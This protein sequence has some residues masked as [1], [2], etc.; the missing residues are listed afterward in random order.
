LE[1]TFSLLPV[2]AVAHGC[3]AVRALPPQAATL[4]TEYPEYPEYLTNFFEWIILLRKRLIIFSFN[5]EGYF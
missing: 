1:N 4:D 2:W 5:E 3:P